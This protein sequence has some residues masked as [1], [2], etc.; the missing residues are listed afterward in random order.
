MVV[1]FSVVGGF[2][3]SWV[4]AFATFL[5]GVVQCSVKSARHFGVVSF[6]IATSTALN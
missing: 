2:I 6:V 3:L 5:G 1:G 4:M